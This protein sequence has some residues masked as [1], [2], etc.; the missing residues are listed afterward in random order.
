MRPELL[1]RAEQLVDVALAIADMNA[2]PWLASAAPWTYLEIS[3]MLPT[4]W[5][6]RSVRTHQRFHGKQLLEW[7]KELIGVYITKH[8]LAYLTDLL[9]DE[10][11][12]SVSDITEA[13]DHHKVVLG[14]TIKEA[15]RITTKKGDT[16]CVVQ[17][18]DETGTI[19]VT[20]FP[21][22][23]EETRRIMG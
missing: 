11:T 1:G 13:L 10:V 17:L 2:P 19:G 18:E 20:I 6:S 8:P 16:M 5:H 14:G 9:K 21:K 4:H 15:R 3:P 12:H 7:E 22:T 23:Y